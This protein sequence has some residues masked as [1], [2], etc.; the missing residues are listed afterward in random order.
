MNQL[1]SDIQQH[2]N[3]LRLA[4]EYSEFAL[5]MTDCAL[6]RPGP[7]ITYVNDG[8]TRMTG[9]S[10]AEALGQSP[11]FLQGPKTDRSVLDRLKHQLQNG[12][13][14]V[15]CTTNYRKDGSSYLV[16]WMIDPIP[17][18]S[19]EACFVAVQKD[20][21]Q[22]D[23]AEQEILRLQKELI[24]ASEQITQLLKVICLADLKHGHHGAP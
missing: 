23:R 19:D 17:A 8:F 6:E 1:R 4:Q 5:I 18:G 2:P 22:R 16:E 7:L 20:L 24:T 21:G 10:A 9:Y 3:L 12:E 13:R 11:R 15:G 14:F